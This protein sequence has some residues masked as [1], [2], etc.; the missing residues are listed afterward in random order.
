MLI[1]KFDTVKDL[2]KYL[3]QFNPEAEV[4]TDMGFS[5]VKPVMATAEEDRNSKMT[6]NI[7]YVY[8]EYNPYYTKYQDY[9]RLKDYILNE[10]TYW[11]DIDDVKLCFPNGE[12]TYNLFYKRNYS[13]DERNKINSG[14]LKDIFS[15]CNEN[16]WD[17]FEDITILYVK[18]SRPCVLEKH[19]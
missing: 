19:L 10:L 11:Y 4:L 5:W 14:I 1:V 13:F 7:L 17:I 18:S 3:E 8:G 9:Y 6:T 2:I 12:P 15:I 16:D